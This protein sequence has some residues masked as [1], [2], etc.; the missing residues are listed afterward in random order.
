MLP[1]V[2]AVLVIKSLQPLQELPIEAG[3]DVPA[4]S[5]ARDELFEYL[6]TPDG[7]YRSSRL[8]TTPPQL[9]AFAGEPIHAV[10]VHEGVVYSAKG[11]VNEAGT[12]PEHTLVRSTDHGLTF[13]NIDSG[14]LDCALPPCE[15]LVPTRIAFG[16]DRIYVNAGGN[17]LASDDAGA[18]WHQLYGLQHQGKPTA[19]ICPVKFTVSGNR[20]LLGGECP[21]DMA[22]LRRGTLGSDL[23]TWAEEPRAVTAPEMENRNVQFIRILAEGVVFAGIEGAL[24]KSTD[25]GATFRYVIHYDLEAPD[26]YPYIG[27]MVVSSRDPRVMIVGG[28]D[29]K[30]EV[31]YLAYSGDSGETWQDLSGLAGTAFVSLLAEDADGRV[32]VGLQDGARFRLAEVVLGERGA[33]R[34]AVR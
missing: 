30:N 19:Q 14:L 23:L 2:L 8:A 29:K 6:A 4:Y 24:M 20:M 33:K 16:P 3:S 11:G 12:S 7:L 13:T 5:Y 21:L 34:R 15:Y 10:A 28:F 27:H 25:G 32:L 26:R 22:W 9:I 1:L 31:G 17:V 18:S